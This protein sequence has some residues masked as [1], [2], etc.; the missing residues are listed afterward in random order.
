MNKKQILSNREIK[1]ITE[2]KSLPNLKEK[3]IRFIEMMII[4]K[5][6]E[7]IIPTL[8]RRISREVFPIKKH[9]RG[10]NNNLHLCYKIL[11]SL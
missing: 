8:K 10:D 9:R 11:G 4:K 6:R 1:I 5:I 3:D 2:Y 7:K